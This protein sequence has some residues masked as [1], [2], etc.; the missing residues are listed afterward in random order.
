[1]TAAHTTRVTSQLELRIV[2]AQI[3]EAF[4][5]ADFE[6]DFREEIFPAIENA[7]KRFFADERDPTGEK[8]KPLAQ[9]TVKRKGHDTILVE[10]GRLK[11]SLTT[12]DGDSIRE[13]L[14]RSANFGT[15]VEYAG[16]HQ[17]GAGVPQREHTGLDE[18]TL[19]K[20][21]DTIAD[22]LV[23]QIRHI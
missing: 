17:E 2:F 4:N 12:P 23:Q 5:H 1:M 15:F 21:V 8:W 11:N 9:A 7:E 16:F 19:D 6:K 10:T 22:S 14:G 20:I 18:P 13:A 3:E